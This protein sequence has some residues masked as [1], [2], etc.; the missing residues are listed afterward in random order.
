MDREVR[1]LRVVRPLGHARLFARPCER[2]VDLAQKTGAGGIAKIFGIRQGKRE[3]VGGTIRLEV[4]PVQPVKRRIARQ[5]Q[6]D[7]RARAAEKYQRPSE[8]RFK[9]GRS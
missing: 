5:D 2:D 8:Q 4:I 7:R 3:D 9:S 1:D 6:R